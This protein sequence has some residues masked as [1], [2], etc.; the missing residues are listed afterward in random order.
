MSTMS[1]DDPPSPP[2]RPAAR[3]AAPLAAGAAERLTDHG[4][5]R[6]RRRA[7][8]RDH[9]HPWPE[10]NRALPGALI[11]HIVVKDA[12]GHVLP[13]QV[14]NVAPQAKDPKNVG[15][16]YGELL[17]QHRLQAPARSATFTVEKDRDAGTAL[18]GQ[19]LCALRAGAPRRLRLGER[20]HRPP[21]LRPRAGRAGAARQRQGSAGDQRHRYLVQ[22]GR[23]SRS[24]TAGTTRATTTTTRTK[25]KAWTCTTSARRAARRHRRLGRREAVHQRELEVLEGAGQRPGARRV[26]AELRQLGCGRHQGREVKRFTVD[27]GHQLDQVESTF[28]TSAAPRS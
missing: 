12:A 7:P 4:Q 18:P 23:L 22:A 20:P 26:R 19:G 27:A 2:G 13:Y 9:R 1:T 17:F 14:T 10:V 21:H 11:Q 16:A 24:S 3:P 6:P 15:A 28:T 8:V 25:A 5:P